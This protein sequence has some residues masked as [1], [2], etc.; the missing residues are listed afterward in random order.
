M[1]FDK[2]FTML[3]LVVHKIKKTTSPLL[4]KRNRSKLNNTDFTIISNNCWAGVCYEYFGLKKNSPT[5]GT[6]IYAEDY[7]KFVNN[8]TYYLSLGIKMIDAP[9]ANHYED[10]KLANHLNVPIGQLDD[11][12]IVFLHYKDPVIAKEKWMRRAERVN[13][14]N[15]IIKFSYMSKCSDKQIFDFQKIHG[16]KKFCFVPKE[17][18]DMTDL[19]KIPSRISSLSDLGDD[20]FDWN[21]YIDVFQLINSP[22]TGIKDFYIEK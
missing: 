5:V 4:A 19:I 3:E 6:Y 15:L 2:N 12:E 22:K 16:I 7:I 20:V 14:E 9:A 8:L 11:V 1:Y 17:F 10:L 21:K 18:V 13:L